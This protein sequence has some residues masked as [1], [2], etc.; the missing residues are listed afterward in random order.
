MVRLNMKK[1]GDVPAALDMND[2][3]LSL[4][5]SSD[6]SVAGKL[7]DGSFSVRSFLRCMYVAPFSTRV[8]AWTRIPITQPRMY[9]KAVTGSFSAY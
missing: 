3:Y 7:A 4:R 9:R 6:P 1:G 2:R 5:S 8:T